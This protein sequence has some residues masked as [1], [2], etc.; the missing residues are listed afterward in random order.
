MWV[1]RNL[2]IPHWAT[3]WVAHVILLWLMISILAHLNIYPSH[4]MISDLWQNQRYILARTLS[5]YEYHDV[6][7]VRVDLG[8]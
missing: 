8:D 4:M 2:D 6:N 1:T 7:I 3:S 5:E